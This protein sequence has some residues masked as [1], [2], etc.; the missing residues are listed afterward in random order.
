MNKF[1]YPLDEKTQIL[2]N[3]L[4]TQIASKDDEIAFKNDEIMAK[5]DEIKTLENELAYLKGQILKKNNKIYGRSSEKVDSD[6]L[7]IFNEAETNA[8]LKQE[9]PTIEAVVVKRKNTTKRTKKESFENLETVV[10]EHKLEDDEKECPTCKGDLHV[11]G[12]KVTEK[13][14]FVPAKLYVEKHIT[15]TYGC[16]R[17]EQEGTEST[18][19]QAKTSNDFLQ[20]S[21][22]TP[23]LIAHILYLKYSHA[24]PLYRQE[25]YFRMLGVELSRQTLSNWVIKA[26]D[27][28]D[29]IYNLMKNELL[30]RD[31]I[32]ADETTVT[33]IHEDGKEAK[34]KKYMW[35]YRTGASIKPVII[36]D[37][38]KT[39]SSSCA[40]NFLNGFNG[41]LQ[42]DGY[43]GYGKVENVDWVSCMAHIRRK[44]YEIIKPLDE[45]A[46][47]KS[48]AI[49]AFNY[50]EKLYKIEK[51]LREKYSKDENYY[52]ERYKVR[53]KESKPIL[54]KFIK[55]IE[56][57]IPNALE[58]SSLSKALKYANDELPKLRYYLEDGKI[59]IDNNGAERA[60][61]PF[62]IGR[63]NWLFM[64]TS[65]GAKA[66]A[67]IYSIIE[68]AK[69]NGLKIDRYLEYIMNSLS[70]LPITERTEENLI[71]IMPWS[72]T[73]PDNIYA[74]AL[75]K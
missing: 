22:A 68:T 40:I 65:K 60:I 9:E 45:E 30:S 67:L 66:S 28:F 43:K 3:Q 39:R 34:S 5:N 56:N 23:E 46:L 29:N 51:H 49:I 52:D 2:I 61:K 7:S 63:K 50:C 55:Y 11:V 59:E 48:R 75:E 26:A 64:N 18:F 31:Y 57:E 53:Q 20:K 62:V 10:I 32:Q 15:Y 16:R 74:R 24:M 42:T 72:N 14:R 36:Y 1:S 13:L 6:Q 38:Q 41:T 25:S 37:Y 71:N 44:F 12:K 35:L 58:K 70:N 17:C 8:N 54:E 27:E 4:H 73:L 21:M 33:V 69:A 47:K 19:V